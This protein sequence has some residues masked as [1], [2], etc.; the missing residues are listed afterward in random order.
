MVVRYSLDSGQH[1]AQSF[2]S[3]KSMENDLC[4]IDLAP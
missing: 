4:A 2:P 3:I 1:K